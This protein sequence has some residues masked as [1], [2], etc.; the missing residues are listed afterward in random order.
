MK[1]ILQLFILLF[2]YSYTNS[3]SAQNVDGYERNFKFGVGLS[4][5]VPFNKPYNFNLGV[6]VRLQYNISKT[7]S[8]TLTAGYNRLFVDD[9][10]VDFGY[11]PIKAGYKTFLFRNEF[12]V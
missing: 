5:G 6:D 9:D 2:V 7:Y 4:G 10:G 3:L 8:L 12:Y 1:K 11:V